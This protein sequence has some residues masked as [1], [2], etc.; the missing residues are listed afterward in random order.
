MEERTTSTNPVKPGQS[1]NWLHKRE[2][3]SLA[4]LLLSD[5]THTGKKLQNFGYR[6]TWRDAVDLRT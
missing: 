2:S 4:F 1:V 5:A 6:Q 3:V